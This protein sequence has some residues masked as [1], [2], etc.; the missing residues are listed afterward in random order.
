MNII[1]IYTKK[2]YTCK[3]CDGQVYYG[4]VTDESGKIVT[5]DGAWPNGKFGKESNVLFN[6]DISMFSGMDVSLSGTGRIDLVS[7]GG[8]VTSFD[9]YVAIKVGGSTKYIQIYS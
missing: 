3:K 1:D 5:K 2:E 4:K 9:G 6:T 7:T 8:S